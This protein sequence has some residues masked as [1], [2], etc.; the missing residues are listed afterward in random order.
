MFVMAVTSLLIYALRAESIHAFNETLKSESRFKEAQ[1]LS[2]IGNWELDLSNN[3][4]TWSEEVYPL[5]EIDSE[6][7]KPSFELFLDAIHPDDRE[8]VDL[9]YK[10]SVT[11]KTPYEVSHRLLMKDG[12]ISKLA[13]MVK[14]FMIIM[15]SLCVLLEQFRILLNVIRLSWRRSSYNIIGRGYLNLCLLLLWVWIVTAILITG[16]NRLKL[17]QNS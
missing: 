3:T 7:Y 2:F 5:F 9:T 13:N 12:R 14:L 16:I 8:L 6:Q 4:L 15:V 17:S 1:H 11:N 10:N